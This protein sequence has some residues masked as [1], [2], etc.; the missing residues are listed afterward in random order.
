MR[1]FYCDGGL[2]KWE[3]GDAPWS[4]HAHWFPHCGYLLLAKGQEF[5]DTYSNKAS[6]QRTVSTTFLPNAFSID[7]QTMLLIYVC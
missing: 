3:A 1:C 4:E 7:D 5:V 2:G 6:V